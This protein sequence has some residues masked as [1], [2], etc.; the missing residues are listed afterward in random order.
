MGYLLGYAQDVSGAPE[1]RGRNGPVRPEGDMLN[2]RVLFDIDSSGATQQD[3]RT[4]QRRIEGNGQVIL[5]VG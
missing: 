1:A 5:G 4:G 2:G 3:L